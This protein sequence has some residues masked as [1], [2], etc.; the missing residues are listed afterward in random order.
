MILKDVASNRVDNSD[1]LCH[2]FTSPPPPLQE[3]TA[4]V[5]VL[6]AAEASQIQ[7]H[8]FFFFVVVLILQ[9]SDGE[10]PTIQFSGGGVMND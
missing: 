4:E 6:V 1:S 10:A 5:S 2:L 3:P 9:G 8:L 7:V